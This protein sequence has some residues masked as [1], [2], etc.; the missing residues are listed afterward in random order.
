MVRGFT[1]V[2]GVKPAERPVA[3]LI[4]PALVP[5]GT[6]VDPVAPEHTESVTAAE[7]LCCCRGGRVHMRPLLHGDATQDRRI[8]SY[9]DVDARVLR[10]Q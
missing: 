2:S 5:V 7:G 4:P 6:R 8:A 1:V 3:N 10:G 9:S